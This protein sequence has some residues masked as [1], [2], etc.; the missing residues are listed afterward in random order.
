MTSFF[1]ILWFKIKVKQSLRYLNASVVI[2]LFIITPFPAQIGTCPI[3]NPDFP[4][5]NAD[6]AKCVTS[7]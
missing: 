1:K 5:Q 3:H 2:L 7:G 6:F 4:N